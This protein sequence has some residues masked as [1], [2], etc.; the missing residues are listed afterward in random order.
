MLFL[1]SCL[2]ILLISCSKDQGE[3]DLGM[4][5]IQSEYSERTCNMHA[6]HHSLMS[7]PEY[8]SSFEKRV[9]KAEKMIRSRG[10][11]DCN[12]PT[13]LP[14]AVHF[15][16]VQNPDAG[17]LTELARSQI[18]ILNQDYRGQNS[19]IS[20]WSSYQGTYPGVS[21][22]DACVVFC[23][24]DKNHPSGFNLQDGDAAVT[25]NQT[26]GD[27]DNR[28]SGYINIFVQF[29]TGVLGYSPLGGSGNGDGVV[30]DASAFGSGQGCGS[31][32]PQAP[33]NLGR[34]LTHELGHY[35]LLDHVWGDNGGCNQDDQVS[36]TPNQD[37][38]NYGCPGT[39]SSCGSPDLHMNYMDYTNDACMFMFSAGQATR[40]ENYIAANLQSV[41]A[42]ANQ[43]CSNV[44]NGDG[45][46][47]G[48][49][50]GGDG[51]GGDEEECTAPEHLAQTQITENSISIV[52]DEVTVATK[53]VVSI[54]EVGTSGWTN[55]QVTATSYTFQD[56]APDTK[57]RIRVRAKCGSERSP[58]TKITV[59]TAE[60]SAPD[61]CD[62]YAV[63]LSITLDDYP[64]ET[65]WTLYDEETF[66]VIATGGP[67]D[68]SQ[69]GS[70]VSAEFCLEDGCYLLEV[71]DA[72]GDGICCDYGE[73]SFEII[74]EGGEEIYFS[75]GYFGSYDGTFFCIEGGSLEGLREKT[76]SKSSA[77][78]RKAQRN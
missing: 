71:E 25:V 67:F 69:G 65:S 20:S 26:N 41:V 59:T 37:Q 58:W 49:D 34:T 6:H 2:F 17:C 21:T 23:L 1:L 33:Y 31:I 16:G 38:P 53:Y 14:V 56:L 77:L 9:A 51:N 54:K 66:D 19:D 68:V 39:A 30:I 24:A 52:W 10:A 44:D 12:E 36:D 55:T 61:A 5:P 11:A 35:L 74:G 13:V 57:Y 60:E 18:Q 63:A 27:S 48:G 78:E 76:S 4:D 3:S 62:D 45:G 15:Q 40:M 47:N 8:R 50:G 22:G 32:A 64:E 70:T 46:G 42:N 72:Y 73:G 75:D 29:N 28:W 7:N 43:V